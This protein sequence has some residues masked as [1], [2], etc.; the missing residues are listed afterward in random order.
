M[1]WPVPTGSP[2]RP[3]G[4]AGSCDAR[5]DMI[6][7]FSFL[8]LYSLDHWKEAFGKTQKRFKKN[9]KHKKDKLNVRKHCVFQ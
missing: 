2:G 9:K 6:I 1:E 7:S 5:D 4:H 3:V 8:F